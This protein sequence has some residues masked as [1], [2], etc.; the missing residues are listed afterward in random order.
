MPDDSE[1]SVELERH[2]DV[3]ILRSDSPH[4]R[5]LEGVA[6]DLTEENELT[7][8]EIDA[9]LRSAVHLTCPV[10]I[11]IDAYRALEGLPV[12]R[13]FSQSGWLYDYRR[14]VLDDDGASIDAVR[15]EYH[16]VFGL[17]IWETET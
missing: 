9:A 5:T 11:D 7:A 14:L 1:E 17:R 2:I 3:V 13:P 16:P 12:P 6:L 15:L 10:D 8:G 4:P